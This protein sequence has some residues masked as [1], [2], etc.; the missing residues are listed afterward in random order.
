[1][2][3]DINKGSGTVYD[4]FRIDSLCKRV[5]KFFIP[6]PGAKMAER[7]NRSPNNYDRPSRPCSA[8]SRRWNES[9]EQ[10]ALRL[11]RQLTQS[12]L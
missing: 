6:S 1:M 5:N 2:D 8:T 4:G 12:L 11:Q 7:G 9:D 3:N 10:R